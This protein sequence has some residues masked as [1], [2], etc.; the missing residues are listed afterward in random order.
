[1]Y[2]YDEEELEIVQTFESGQL[3]S[4]HP[5]KETL[6]R[7]RAYAEKSLSKNK[8][9]NIRLSE[10]DLEEI[11]IRALEEGIPYQTLMGSVLHKYL[12]GR[13]VEK[14]IERAV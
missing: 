4:Q 3:R 13:L 2:D 6:A 1:M 7:H 9:V 14:T 12:S 10:K 8:R 5:D 11:K